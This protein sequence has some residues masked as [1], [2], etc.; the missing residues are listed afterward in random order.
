MYYDGRTVVVTVQYEGLGAPGAV[1]EVWRRPKGRSQATVTPRYLP[2]EKPV[3]LKTFAS[4]LH[5][6]PQSTTSEAWYG[7]VVCSTVVVHVI[8]Q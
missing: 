3:I 4:S 2:N 8:V 7:A 6:P 5:S 1:S